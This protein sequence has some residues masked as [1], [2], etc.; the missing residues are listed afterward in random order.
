VKGRT[1]GTTQVSVKGKACA[2]K[3]AFE[4]GSE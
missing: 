3:I 1:T 2:P 4:W